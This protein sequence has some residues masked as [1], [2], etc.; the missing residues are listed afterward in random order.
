MSSPALSR[1]FLM[2]LLLSLSACFLEKPQP[3]PTHTVIKPPTKDE[4]SAEIQA[5]QTRGQHHALVAQLRKSPHLRV[6]E[7][8]AGAILAQMRSGNVFRISGT[9]INP[10]FQPT[11]EHIAATLTAHPWLKVRI[12]GHTDNIG[13]PQQNLTLSVYRAQRVH[14]ALVAL[15]VDANK[16]TYE[17]RGDTDPLVSNATEEGRAVNRRVDLLFTGTPPEQTN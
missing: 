5:T 3:P 11:F 13:D 4:V 14:D 8:E 1:L 6:N 10:Q 16:V 15:G 12:I 17:G 2:P 9:T 7:T